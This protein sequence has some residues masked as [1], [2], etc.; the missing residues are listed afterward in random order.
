MQSLSPTSSQSG[1]DTSALIKAPV[2]HEWRNTSHRCP[3]LDSPGAA[4]HGDVGGEL[5]M[6]SLHLLQSINVID[7]G[8]HPSVNISSLQTLEFRVVGSIQELA[9]LDYAL[10]YRF[11]TGFIL[12]TSS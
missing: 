12:D 9:K 11:S 4:S 5:S 10:N 2:A 6:N 8:I 1:K 7:R 3:A